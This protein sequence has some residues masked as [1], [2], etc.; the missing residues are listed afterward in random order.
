MRLHQPKPPKRL[1][2][3]QIHRWLGIISPSLMWVHQTKGTPEVMDYMDRCLRY[4]ID[5]R[6]CT[7]TEWENYYRGKRLEA[8]H[9]HD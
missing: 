3:S 7:K 1:F 8:D 2:R 9:D 5:T 4:R 6:T